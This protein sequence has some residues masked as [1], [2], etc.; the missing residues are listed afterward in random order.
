M[1]SF[2]QFLVPESAEEAVSLK[3][4]VGARALYVA[5][6]TTIV[7]SASDAIEILI[8]V[9]RLGL[10]GMRIGLAFASPDVVRELNKVKDSYNLDRLS[11]VAAR[12]A[13]E[14]YAWMQANV[15]K[16]RAAREDLVADL[17]RLGFQ[18]LPSEANFVFASHPTLGGEELY[19]K[20]R[21]AG[22]LVRHFGSPALEAGVRI[23]VGTP[24]EN[25]ALVNALHALLSH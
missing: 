25:A 1:K 3:K 24:E 6:G 14:D 2:R 17:K 12:A 7:P 23:T 8:D 16:V 5:G 22:I 18:V 20:L 11:L 15:A 9:S 19:G 4:E 21:E 13:L 10:A